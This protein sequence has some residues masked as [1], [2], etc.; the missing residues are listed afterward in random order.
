MPLASVVG[1]GA[2]VL[3]KWS[4]PRLLEDPEAVRV[5]AMRRHLRNLGTLLI[6]IVFLYSS[7]CRPY[8]YFSPFILF[9]AEILYRS[10]PSVCPL[11]WTSGNLI[12]MY[13]IPIL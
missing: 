9:I 11:E 2:Y 1:K 4:K 3:G 7:G 13:L 8:L 6:S 12:F 10:Y 5:C